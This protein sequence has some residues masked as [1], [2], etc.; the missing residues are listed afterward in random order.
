MSWTPAPYRLA[1]RWVFA[2]TMLLVTV[3]AVGLAGAL[4]YLTRAFIELV[5]GLL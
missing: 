5:R 3:A 4:V 2:L 1:R